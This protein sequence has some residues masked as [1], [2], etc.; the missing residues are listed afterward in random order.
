MIN[1]VVMLGRLVEDPEL[2]KTPSEISVTRFTIAV[3]RSYQKAGQER[4]SDFF[5]I[6]AWRSTAEFI[7]RYFK[8]GSMIAITGSLQTRSYEDKNGQKRKAYEIVVDQASFCEGRRN[9]A[10]TPAPA[11]SN[12]GNGYQTAP[13]SF[14]TGS[15]ADFEEIGSDDDLPF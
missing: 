3:D 7:C 15:D 5:D 9:D 14:A 6:V 12:P 8:K 4:Q 13:Q 2:R 11:A 10:G 1:N